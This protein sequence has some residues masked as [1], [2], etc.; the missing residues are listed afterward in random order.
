MTIGEA[1]EPK[2]VRTKESLLEA[3][4]LDEGDYNENLL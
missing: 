3:L 2:A 4:G 1:L